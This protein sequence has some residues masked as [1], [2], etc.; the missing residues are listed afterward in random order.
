[1]R[2]ARWLSSVVSHLRVRAVSLSQIFQEYVTPPS[3]SF[4]LVASRP[5]PEQTHGPLTGERGQAA[6]AVRDGGGP[7]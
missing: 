1:M 5:T 7:I 3:G 6:Q 4:V 2:S